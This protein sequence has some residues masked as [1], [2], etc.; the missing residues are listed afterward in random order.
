MQGAAPRHSS[1]SWNPFAFPSRSSREPFFSR[2]G[3]KK[4]G[5]FLS[6]E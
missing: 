2:E 5:R 3:A 6:V 4:K 1:E